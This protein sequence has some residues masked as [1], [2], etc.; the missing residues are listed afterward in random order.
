MQTLSGPVAIEVELQP[1][2]AT[3]LRG[4][5]WMY[6]QLSEATTRRSTASSTSPTAQDVAR[7]VTRNAAPMGLES[8]SLR[9]LDL[10]IQQTWEAAGVRH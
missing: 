10:V 4:I 3:R 7:L 5:C 8:L 6:A 9:T 1:K 2:T